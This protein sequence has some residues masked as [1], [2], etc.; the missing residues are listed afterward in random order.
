MDND[1][2]TNPDRTLEL[3]L[4]IGMYPIAWAAV[5]AIV[6]VA[7]HAWTPAELLQPLNQRDMDAYLN[8]L[9]KS[10]N[11]ARRKSVRPYYARRRARSAHIGRINRSR[12]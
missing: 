7:F 3:L 6:L 1:L 9:N 11:R 4:R 5:L 10:P 8:R 2:L 12:Q